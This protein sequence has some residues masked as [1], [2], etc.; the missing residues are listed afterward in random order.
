MRVG[1]AA[2]IAALAVLG[3]AMPIAQS[4]M[5]IAPRN[6]P[7]IYSADPTDPWN[8]L[9]AV[10]LTRRFQVRFT[11]EFADRGPFDAERDPF[12]LFSGQPR[13]RASAR[14][15]DRYEE[16]DRAVDALYPAFLNQIGPRDALKEPLHGELVSA[17]TAALA[18]RTERSPVARVLMQADL[19]SAYDPLASIQYGRGDGAVRTAAGE[20]TTLLARLVGRLAL[21]PREIATL[22]N[23]YEDARRATSLP[24]LFR[25]DGEWMEIVWGEFRMHDAEEAFRRSARVFVRPGVRPSDPAS[26]LMAATKEPRPI[27]LSA[28]ALVMQAIA[29]D[30]SGQ[31]VPTPLVS[32]VQIRTF[33]RDGS[34]A[35][36]TKTDEYELSR[37]KL[38]SDRSSGGF[39]HFGDG[40]EA[41][42]AV[43]GNDYGFATPAMGPPRETEPTICTLR[44][45]CLACH[46]PDGTHMMSFAVQDPRR[47][48][49]PRVLPQ[50]NDERARYVAQ[51]KE[52]RDD[53]K[54]LIEA[55][56]L[57]R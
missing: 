30:T 2:A 27:L 20:L 12:R 33:A 9:F 44:T 47:M 26:F 46:G 55:A 28:V 18:D 8:R 35:V 29:I 22:P 45:R 41:Y 16:G 17:L 21:T 4:P 40:S 54:H 3:L 53:F 19:W 50:P 43:A 6:L 5:P 11:S 23:N 32:D 31:A 25:R 38:L 56:G 42:V 48:P 39:L 13:L 7:R 34:S 36:T 15:F 57:R 14:T 1:L 52:A 51:Q 24:D 49:P 37:R 10:L